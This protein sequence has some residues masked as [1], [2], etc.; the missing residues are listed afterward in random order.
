MY[1]PEYVTNERN[2]SNAGKRS[3]LFIYITYC[4]EYSECNVNGLFHQAD[5]REPERLEREW[6][7]W[8]QLRSPLL[9][10]LSLY[11]K[12]LLLSM[13]IRKR[14]P[15]AGNCLLSIPSKHLLSACYVPSTMLGARNTWMDKVVTVPYQLE[16]KGQWG[17]QL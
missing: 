8:G 13:V 3:Y 9:R 2:K 7:E 10:S 14:K 6:S 4:E 16:R 15:A 17:K 12:P 5:L 1:I 11:D